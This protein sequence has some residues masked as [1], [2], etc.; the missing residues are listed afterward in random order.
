M[1]EAFEA[2]VRLSIF[3]LGAGVG[4]VG[5]RGERWGD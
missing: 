4:L 3:M 2:G 5:S 1:M